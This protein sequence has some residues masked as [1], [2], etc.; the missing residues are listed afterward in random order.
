MLRRESRRLGIHLKHIWSDG[1]RNGDKI[2]WA[3]E[4]KRQKRKGVNMKENEYRSE[5]KLQGKE[6]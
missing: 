5:N 3:G 6:K 2:L 4:M 1:E